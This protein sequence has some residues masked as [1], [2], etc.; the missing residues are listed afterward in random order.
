MSDLLSITYRQSID[1]DSQIYKSNIERDIYSNEIDEIEK[2]FLNNKYLWFDIYD[3][4][5]DEELETEPDAMFRY[6][7]IRN[8][9]INGNVD[10]VLDRIFIKN[11]ANQHFSIIKKEITSSIGN[12]FAIYDDKR[13]IEFI[14]NELN[15]KM[16]NNSKDKIEEMVDRLELLSTGKQI[17]ICNRINYGYNKLLNNLKY[18]LAKFDDEFKRD[19]NGE[20]NPELYVK[21]IDHIKE[22]IKIAEANVRYITVLFRYAGKATGSAETILIAYK[23]KKKAIDDFITA[24]RQ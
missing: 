9:T 20:K 11:S 5:D 2:S 19:K 23:A 3:Y 6:C 4:I 1:K 12:N 22:Y 13:L 7:D 17:H 8:N 14:D 24:T 21:I 15:K 16:L 18:D 10:E